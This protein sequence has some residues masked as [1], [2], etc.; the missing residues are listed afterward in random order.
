MGGRLAKFRDCRAAVSW[1]EEEA[2]SNLQ[3]MARAGEFCLQEAILTALEQQPERGLS[4]VRHH[5]RAGIIR[6]RL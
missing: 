6:N 5:D 4:V 3:D 2:M 1:K